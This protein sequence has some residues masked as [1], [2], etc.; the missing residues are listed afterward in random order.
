M[1]TWTLEGIYAHFRPD[2]LAAARGAFT[3][4]RSYR[5]T[6]ISANQERN[7]IDGIGKIRQNAPFRLRRTVG[8][9]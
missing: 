7:E 2:H 1:T 6:T 5:A 8:S 4:H 3:P 9:E